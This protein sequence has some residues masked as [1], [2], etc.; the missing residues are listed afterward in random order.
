[1]VGAAPDPW[2]PTVTGRTRFRLLR[3]LVSV[4][5]MVALVGLSA[6]GSTAFMLYREF[7]Q[8]RTVISLPRF[9]ALIS[10]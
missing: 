2:G 6:V 8:G 3:R 1:M 7:D 5:G 4:L 9:I 10:A